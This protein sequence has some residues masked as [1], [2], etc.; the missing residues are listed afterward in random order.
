MASYILTR[1][2]SA[3]FDGG[4]LATSRPTPVC[5]WVTLPDE[6]RRAEAEAVA[7]ALRERGISA[8]ISPKARKFGKQ[9]AA[10]EARGV[11]FVWFLP[12]DRPG[13]VKDIRSGEEREADPAS[14]TP[15]EDDLRPRLIA[16]DQAS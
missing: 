1:L 10:A 2:L 5:V 8:D 13:R 9:I 16:G 7:W 4:L 14:W 3:C 6:A 11:P 12:D 15:D